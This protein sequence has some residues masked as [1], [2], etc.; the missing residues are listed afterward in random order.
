MDDFKII[1]RILAAIRTAE[2]KGEFDTALVDEKVIK[3]PTAKRDALAMKLQAEGYVKGLFV[4]DDIDNAPTAVMWQYSRPEVTLAGL[5]YISENSALQKALKEMRDD[6]ISLAAQ[7]VGA[8]IAN[9]A[10]R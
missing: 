8:A 10:G 4:V 7:S 2:G 1:V 9:M 5:A 6:A 3:A